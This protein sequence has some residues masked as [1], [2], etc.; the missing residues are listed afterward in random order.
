MLSSVVGVGFWALATRLFSPSVVGANSSI[1]AAIL[2]LA[3]ISQLNLMSA[4]LRFVP[5]AGAG[6]R[7][8]VSR[9]FAMGAALS[10]LSAVA[11]LAGLSWWA[12]DLAS[13]LEHP[14]SQC[15]FVVAT[16][17]W[18]VFVMEDAVLVAMSRPAAVPVSN[19]G[20]AL[21][22]LVLV[23]TTFAVLPSAGVWVSWTL[24]SVLAVA[25]TASY[26]YGSALPHFVGARSEAAAQLPS[27]ADVV[28]FIGPD[29]LG[30]LAWIGATT[31]LPL[32]VL[33]FSDPSHAAAFT[34]AW[35][36]GSALYEIPAAFGQSLVVQGVADPSRLAKYHDAL[37]RR[38]LLIVGAL[39][40]GL[41]LG[42]PWVMQCFGSYYRAHGTTTL[43]LIALS[44]LPDVVVALAISRFR[45]QSRTQ[46]VFLAL[47]AFFALVATGAAL[48]V[49]RW[50]IG[51]AGAAVLVAQGV[52]ALA[53]TGDELVRRIGHPRRIT[54]RADVSALVAALPGG[55][56]AATSH[57]SRSDTA[58]VEL[59]ATDGRRSMLKVAVSEQG[60]AAIVRETD[61]LRLISA[62]P[63]L[64]HLGAPVLAA[65]ELADRCY[66]LYDRI[67][68]ENG[69]DLTREQARAR[70]DAVFASLQPLHRW[71]S[72]RVELGPGECDELISRSV[73]VLEGALRGAAL[74]SSARELERA[75]RAD[76]T[77][78]RT[79]LAWTHGDVHP[80]NVLFAHRG[81]VAGIVDWDG[82]RSRDLPVL[83]IALWLLTTTPS[84]REFG[85]DVV[86]RL[87]R[88]RIWDV[89]ENT[90]LRAV[91]GDDA[92]PEQAVLLLTWLRH[93][94]NNLGKSARY[95]GNPLWM[96][97]NVAAVLRSTSNLLTESHP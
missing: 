29:Y 42:A 1:L 38:A 74:Q 43:R 82:A 75:L 64:R 6:A 55:W 87:Q 25:A 36:I 92:L 20:F 60:D 53:V 52:V 3:G 21:V 85:S 69:A 39:A 22:K 31:L 17:A 66:L 27:L 18:S 19:L 8:L 58:S 61:V 47:A 35:T 26:L 59:E 76:L 45:A 50:G 90:H 49:S 51:G 77:G 84:R 57:R 83:D 71:Q 5:V 28:R 12:P 97:R 4:L 11:F 13:Y 40:T 91:Q 63:Q 33:N 14:A 24:A 70:S 23:G 32:I 46:P 54:V 41:V 68:G 62:E 89:E 86:D 88:P 72:E 44:A 2:F 30:S 7:A 16:A 96:S 67:E 81:Q 48:G 34:L 37:R 15:A 78:R 9:A 80:G 56:A 65:S 93:V 73:R 94:S 95:A 79:T 10:A